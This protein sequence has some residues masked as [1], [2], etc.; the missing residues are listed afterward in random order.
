LISGSRVTFPIMIA[1]LKN[2]IDVG[3]RARSALYHVRITDKY[4]TWHLL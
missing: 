3:C 2:I 1:L 4:S